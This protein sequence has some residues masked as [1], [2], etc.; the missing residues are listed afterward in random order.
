MKKQSDQV[1]YILWNR[2]VVAQQL[3]PQLLVWSIN[4]KLTNMER[5]M[6]QGEL[7]GCEAGR[8]VMAILLDYK[9][10]G[11]PDTWRPHHCRRRLVEL[12]AMWTR[13]CRKARLRPLKRVWDMIVECAYHRALESQP[14]SAQNDRGEWIHL[15]DKITFWRTYI[16]EGCGYDSEGRDSLEEQHRL[17]MEQHH[18]DAVTTEGYPTPE[19]LLMTDLVPWRQADLQNFMAQYP[20]DSPAVAVQLMP[21]NAP[22]VLAQRDLEAAP[23]EQILEQ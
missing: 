8:L 2:K 22:M 5:R 13:S 21:A 23:L 6:M 7:T 12:Q 16:L 14:A 11:P 15:Q 9:P 17:C 3:K 20:A 18:L 4:N 19:E 10:H 1:E